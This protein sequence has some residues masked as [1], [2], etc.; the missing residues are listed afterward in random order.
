METLNWAV[1]YLKD[2]F[3]II[4]VIA[5]VYAFFFKQLSSRFDAYYKEKLDAC[6]I[7][8]EIV[9]TIANT[10]D[11]D[12]LKA[13]IKNFDDLYYGKLV[14]IEGIRLGNAMV[15]LRNLLLGNEPLK[16]DHDVDWV[17]LLAAKKSNPA[18][19]RQAALKVSRACYREVSP[20]VVDAFVTSIFA[21]PK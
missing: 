11:L 13:A 12:T 21:L 9:A 14:L 19:I 16:K 18:P 5:V 4:V 1:T 3:S 2:N 20:S 10:D 6:K 17:S 8:A 15:S 7:T